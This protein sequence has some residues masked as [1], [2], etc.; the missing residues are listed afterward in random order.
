MGKVLRTVGM[1]AG[2]VALV[3]TGVGAVAGAAFAASAAGAT[4]ASI[5]TYAGLASG[6]AG[7]ASATVFAP[8][9]PPARG[10]VSQ[11]VIQTDAPQ[12]Y[13]MGEGYVGGVMR[14]RIAYGATLK[15]VPNPYL[16]EVHVYSGGGPINAIT[17]YVD[18]EAVSAWY[19]SYLYTDTQLGA[20]PEADALALNYAGAPGWGASSK[21][22]GQAAIAWNLKFDKEGKRFASGVPMLGAYVQGVK[23]YDPRL[24]S[25]F[26]GGSGAHRINDESTW[27]Y[28]ANPALHALAYAYGRHQNSKRVLGIGIP[29]DGIRIDQVAAWAN[30]CDANGWTL[31][32]R[33]FEPGDRW[34]NLRDICAAGGGEPVFSQAMLG[35]R[36]STPLVAL[37]TVTRDDIVGECSATRMAS[38]RDRINTLVP[39]YI[40]SAHNW[41][42]VAAEPVVVAGYV[43]ADGEE[44]RTEWPF[45]LV[46]DKDQA[47]QLGRYRLEDSR[48]L[49][50]IVLTCSP[51]LRAYRPGECLAI[52]LPELGL[53]TD[54]VILEREIDP[55]TMT[56]KLT[57]MGETPAKHAAALAQAGTAPATPVAGLTGEERDILL[58][59]A[60]TPPGYT[61][62]LITG[63]Y[64]VDADP[65]D[66][67]LQATDTQITIESHTRVYADKTLSLTGAT[68]TTEDDGTTA[69]VATTTYHIYYDDGTRA[70]T[71]P[72]FKAT[73]NSTLAVNDPTNPNRH[74]VGSITTD[75]NGGTGTTGGGAFPSGWDISYWLP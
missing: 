22:S 29:A 47:A 34:T 66:G 75:V 44:K 12:P 18:Q 16:L 17:P 7:I 27:S 48:E 9:P 51:R 60:T 67:L 20:C 14:H 55:A 70:D 71:T 45:N 42:M 57:L 39:K 30:D 3:A 61:E 26:A 68:L 43:T 1:I 36:W 58:D 46:K 15:K 59:A 50:P 38:Y 6:I 31:F 19:S 56:V 64:V 11:T 28:S 41:E 62:G 10:S 33:V 35:F 72:D 49:Q 8:K 54:A 24:D 65:L 73:Q 4:V 13:V 25:T 63:S 32:G 21:L 37:D 40:S 69:I 23:V 52:D 2:A 74:Y 5:A 53:A